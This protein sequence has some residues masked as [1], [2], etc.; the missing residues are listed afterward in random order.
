MNSKPEA[1]FSFVSVTTS[2]PE[3]LEETKS[4]PAPPEVPCCPSAMLGIPENGVLKLTVRLV[5]LLATQVNPWP[6]TTV[7]LALT[8]PRMTTKLVSSRVL[9]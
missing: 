2:K 6:Q 3:V 9:I 5:P 4:T 1:P 8:L 7:P